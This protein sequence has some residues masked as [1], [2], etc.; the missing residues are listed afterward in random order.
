[1]DC[2]LTPK[3]FADLLGGDSW[4]DVKSATVVLIN[5]SVVLG[6]FDGELHDY[7]IK[8]SIV[9]ISYD[10]EWVS[11]KFDREKRCL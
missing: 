1:M 11:I 2:V 5:G 6:G 9:R 4:K 7:S 3:M 8:D 10:D